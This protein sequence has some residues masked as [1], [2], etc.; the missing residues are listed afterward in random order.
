MNVITG[1]GS[2]SQGSSQ[3]LNEASRPGWIEVGLYLLYNQN[4]TGR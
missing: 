4:R 1:I 2:D 3:A